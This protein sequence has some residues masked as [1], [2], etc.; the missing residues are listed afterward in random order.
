MSP[1]Y[2]DFLEKCI[3]ITEAHL[4]DPA[5]N[6]QILA[7]EVGMSHSALY[8]R[9]KSISGKSINEFIRFIRLRKAATLYIDSDCNVNEGAF[10]A[11]FNDIKYF[12]EQFSKLY[13]VNP[14]E[15]IKKYR[16]PFN[17]SYK[18]TQKIARK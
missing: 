9:V 7:D 15:Y 17:K 12:R 11:G 14:S 16:K 5:F 3:S 6:I 1:E 2:K 18:L 13:G 4:D 8:K 10:Q